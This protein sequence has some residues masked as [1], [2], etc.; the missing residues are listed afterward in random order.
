MVTFADDLS[1]LQ[2]QDR[3]EQIVTLSHRLRKTKGGSVV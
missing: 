1:G 2:K 3:F